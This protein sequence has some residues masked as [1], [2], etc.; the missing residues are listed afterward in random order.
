MKAEQYEDAPEVP[1]LFDVLGAVA[2]VAAVGAQLTSKPITRRVL[3][4]TSV[5]AGAPFLYKNNQHNSYFKQDL[6][7]RDIPF[8]PNEL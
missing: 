1:V 5:V 8:T 6:F 4:G 3:I 2:F 7:G